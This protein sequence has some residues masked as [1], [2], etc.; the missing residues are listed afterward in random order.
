MS[1]GNEH[2]WH[3]TAK[4]LPRIGE[5]QGLMTFSYVVE[6]EKGTKYQF[7]YGIGVRCYTYPTGIPCPLPE[8][9][10][11]IDSRLSEKTLKA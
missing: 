7:G 4:E 2:E 3:E 1:C 8:K 6:D 9:W 10:R 5:R 11:Y